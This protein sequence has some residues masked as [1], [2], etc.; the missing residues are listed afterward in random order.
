V[1]TFI[2]SGPPLEMSWGIIR[3]VDPSGYGDITWGELTKL[4][5]R[6]EWIQLDCDI[7]TIAGIETYAIG[8]DD[9]KKFSRW[10]GILIGDVKGRRSDAPKSDEVDS[11]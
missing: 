10:I 3:Y 1:H 2:S 6:K 8:R 7:V 11:A 5:E 9:D 4:N